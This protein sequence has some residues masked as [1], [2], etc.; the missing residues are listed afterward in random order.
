MSRTIWGGWK[1]WGSYPLH[2]WLTIQCCSVFS[3]IIHWISRLIGYHWISHYP[4]HSQP[5]FSIST[6]SSGWFSTI[7]SMFPQLPHHHSNP[8]KNAAGVAVDQRAVSSSLG[9]V[10]ALFEIH[11]PFSV[12]NSGFCH[13]IGNWSNQKYPK[14]IVVLLPW[15]RNIFLS[16]MH[17]WRSWAASWPS[18]QLL[19]WQSRRSAERRPSGHGDQLTLEI[20]RADTCL[21]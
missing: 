11:V 17:D 8:A 6:I 7:P 19:G 2:Q 15:N 3:H 1:L 18:W 4:L 10:D 12:E 16:N 13:K 21:T 14:I 5:M 9:L 20:F